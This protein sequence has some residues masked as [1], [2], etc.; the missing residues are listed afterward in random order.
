MSCVMVATRLCQSEAFYVGV[1][2]TLF[3]MV[4]N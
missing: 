4:V 1:A 3:M 2:A